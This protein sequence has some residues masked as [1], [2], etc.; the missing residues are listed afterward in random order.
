MGATVDDLTLGDLA[1]ELTQ[2]DG[3]G[4]RRIVLVGD[5][6]PGIAPGVSCATRACRS[7]NDVTFLPFTPVI[8]S[9][10]AIP[11]LASLLDGVTAATRTPTGVPNG[12]MASAALMLRAA[13]SLRVTCPVAMS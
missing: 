11:A 7:A 5:R 2:H 8:R 13:R 9:P 1:L 3:D 4:A 10:A 12:S 6:Y